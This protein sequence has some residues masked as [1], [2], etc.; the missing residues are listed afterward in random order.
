MKRILLLIAIIT[1]TITL[2][3]QIKTTTSAV[4]AFD[5]TTSLDKLPKAENKTVIGKIDTKNGTIA[6]E[7]AVKSF[8]FSN[9]TIQSSFNE[10][11]WL[12]SSVFPL[13]TFTGKI[14]D[15]TKVNFGKNGTYNVPVSGYLTIKG[16]KMPL[17]TTAK[18]VVTGETVNATSAFSIKLSDY[19]I[20]GVPG[21][22]AKE[23][24]ITVSASFK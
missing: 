3:A 24:G 13:F 8:T 7:A 21:K 18:L 11:R 2:Y 6:F 5:A 9:P 23:A 12:N 19:G 14:T 10:D 16:I 20:S 15:L 22:V 4:I 1:A 17:I